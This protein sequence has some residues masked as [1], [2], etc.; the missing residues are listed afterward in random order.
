MC[1]KCNGL[2]VEM[3]YPDAG[4]GVKCLTCGRNY[5]HQEPEAWEPERHHGMRDDKI[6][7][8]VY[9]TSDDEMRKR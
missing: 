9:T 4:A 6:G 7:V 1:P 8:D 2:L 3:G 5:Y